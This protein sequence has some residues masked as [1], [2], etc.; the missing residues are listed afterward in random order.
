MIR[1]QDFLVPEV[2]ELVCT[3]RFFPSNGVKGF[4]AT[5]PYPDVR[6]APFR[7]VYVV[8]F[9]FKL[10]VPSEPEVPAFNLGSLISKQSSVDYYIIVELFTIVSAGSNEEL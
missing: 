6:Q 4:P 7:F 1:R 3:Y 9:P 10:Y 2:M 8:A 5:H